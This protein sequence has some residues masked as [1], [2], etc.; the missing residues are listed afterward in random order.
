MNNAL[1]HGVFQKCVHLCIYSPSKAENILISLA[2][3]VSLI[4]NLFLVS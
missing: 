4:K 3:L 1:M 2:A